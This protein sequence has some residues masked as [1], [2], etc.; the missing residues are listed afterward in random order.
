MQAL[1]DL[2]WRVLG[3]ANRSR[4]TTV[5][6]FFL[7]TALP[8]VAVV[9]FLAVTEGRFDLEDLLALAIILGF[10]AVLWYGLVGLGNLILVR[11]RLVPE[12]PYGADPR[13][14]AP[15]GSPWVQIGA[16]PV[17]I[18]TFVAGNTVLGE[19]P[20]GSSWAVLGGGVLLFWVLD[21]VFLA[22]S[23]PEDRSVSGW[24]PALTESTLLAISW[25]IAAVL[26]NRSTGSALLYGVIAWIVFTVM[27]LYHWKVLLPWLWRRSAEEHGDS[28]GTV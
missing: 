23:R 6:F 11:A 3:W 9:V 22:R 14:A 2:M 5:T 24:V 19:H 20:P 7:L 28:E 27:L 13:T 1:W 17:G 18:L 16:F 25:A 4:W 10:L 8:V 12:P 15:P 21:L 26:A